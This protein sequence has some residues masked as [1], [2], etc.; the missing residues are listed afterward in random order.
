MSFYIAIDFDGTIVEH[1]FPY[2]GEPVDGAIS[3]MK[4]FQKSGAEL[5]LWTMRSGET[6]DAAVEYCKENGIEFIYHNEHP[7]EWT[8]SKKAYAHIYIDD[9]A[10]GCPVV[11]TKSGSCVVNW[12][13]VGPVVEDRIKRNV[14][15]AE[16][17]RG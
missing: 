6:L 8:T 17:R 14:T 1:S 16:V 3:W 2:I 4:L 9:A 5:I 11:M 10:F 7:Q 12:D 15:Y 13:I